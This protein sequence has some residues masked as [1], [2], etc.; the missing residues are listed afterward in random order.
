MPATESAPSF[1]P[2]RDADAPVDA[3]AL[4]AGPAVVQVKVAAGLVDYPE[5]R[6][7]M[8]LYLWT[9]DLAAFPDR[10]LPAVR[11]RAEAAGLGAALRFRFRADPDPARATA[12]LLARFHARFGATP[13]LNASPAS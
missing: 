8:V 11:A 7:A 12:A 2:W 1:S 5:G 4:P 9:P 3:D 10:I 13:R 6:S